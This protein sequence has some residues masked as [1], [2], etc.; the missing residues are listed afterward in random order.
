MRLVKSEKA[1]SLPRSSARQALADAIVERDTVT[2]RTQGNRVARD[3][4]QNLIWALDEKIE[5]ANAAIAEATQEYANHLAKTAAGED[6]VQ[7]VSIRQRRD[8]AQHLQDEIAASR[9]ALAELDAQHETLT[10]DLDWATRKVK[11]RAADV[12]KA[13]ADFDELVAKFHAAWREFISLRE[14]LAFLGDRNWGLLPEKHWWCTSDSR[15]RD[16]DIPGPRPWKAA[17]EA[18]LTDPDALLPQEI[19]G[20]HVV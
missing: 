9:L 19:E 18:L 13:H 6:V 4:I 20:R 17:M 12:V 15:T 8:E 10:R 11:D 1:I 16:W 7:P 5:L 2:R 14:T 3:N